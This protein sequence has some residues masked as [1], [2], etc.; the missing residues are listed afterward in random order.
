MLSYAMQVDYVIL[1]VAAA[2]A[3]LSP[4][5]IVGVH[6]AH[7]RAVYPLQYRYFA[8]ELIIHR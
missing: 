8:K 2:I 4:Q 7:T 5:L 1:L 6:G 3:V